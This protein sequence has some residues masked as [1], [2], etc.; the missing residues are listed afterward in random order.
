MMAPMT[1]WSSI[2]L[3]QKKFPNLHVDIM[4]IL[5]NGNLAPGQFTSPGMEI[6]LFITIKLMMAL[7]MLIG[8]LFKDIMIIFDHRFTKIFKLLRKITKRHFLLLFIL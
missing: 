8:L 7:M 1:T 5:D 3:S 4:I 2:H 6:R